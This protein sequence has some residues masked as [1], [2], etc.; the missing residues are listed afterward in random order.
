MRSGAGGT[1]TDVV[2]RYL[3]ELQAG[4]DE[5]AMAALVS[6]P[7]LRTRVTSFRR[8]FPDLRVATDLLIAQ[9]DLVA[10]HL[11]GRATHQGTFQGVPPTG[12]PWT[13]TCTA[14][15]RVAGGRINESWIDWDKL[16]IVEQIGGFTRVATA[17][18]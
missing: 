8:A 12:R 16:A 13:A 3:D 18:A 1:P 9:D 7:G 5:T 2:R 11:T 6:D 10:V 14:I 4:T 17:S 15:Y